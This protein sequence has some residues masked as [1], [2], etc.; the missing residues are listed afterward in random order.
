MY[1]KANLFKWK[2][3]NT[4]NKN[5]PKSEINPEMVKNYLNFSFFLKYI[6]IVTFNFLY[7]AKEKLQRQLQI[8][9]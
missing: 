7:W 5:N 3:L 9:A 4:K 6:Y 8:S 2:L 1:P